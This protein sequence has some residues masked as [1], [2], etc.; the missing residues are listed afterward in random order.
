ML[1]DT[2]TDTQRQTVVT[3]TQNLRSLWRMEQ[4]YKQERQHRLNWIRL[5]QWKHHSRTCLTR[6]QPR[7]PL[8]INGIPLKQCKSNTAFSFQLRRSERRA[9]QVTEV[10]SKAPLTE[11][12][13]ECHKKRTGSWYD[14]ANS[15]LEFHLYRHKW[16]NVTEA[17]AEQCR[18]MQF[19]RLHILKGSC[20]NCLT[21]F[22]IF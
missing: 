2:D 21:Q 14:N 11:T 13:W 8:K 5:R 20:N 1:I 4:C 7:K 16:G 18:G 22:E 15:T 3:W 6:Q 9:T 17:V 19:N 12:D 10:T